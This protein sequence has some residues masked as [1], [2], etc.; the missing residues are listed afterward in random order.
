MELLRILYEVAKKV[1]RDIE[2]CTFKKG[3]FTEAN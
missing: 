2:K 3:Q 1:W